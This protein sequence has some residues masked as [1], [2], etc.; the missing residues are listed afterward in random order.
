RGLQVAHRALGVAGVQLDVARVE[1]PQVGAEPVDAHRERR[2]RA[3]VR[4][5][6]GLAD[7]LR[8]EPRARAV[9]GA[10]VERRP[11]DDDVG[12][13]VG[14]RVGPV[15]AAHPEKRDVGPELR[16]VPARLRRFART[17]AHGATSSAGLAS[18]KPDGLRWNPT[19]STGITGQSSTRGTWWIPKTYQS[20]T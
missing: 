3:V 15:A 20:T 17:L 8:A 6:A 5:V 11:E 9:R 14:R 1:H 2:S 16:A 19:M 10:A 7:V 4:E 18:K 12:V 13:G